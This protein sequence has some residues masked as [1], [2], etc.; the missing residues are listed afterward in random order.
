[1]T[2][3]EAPKG[4]IVNY[5]IEKVANGYVL[6]VTRGKDGDPTKFVFTYKNDLLT[7]LGERL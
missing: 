3:T 5:R 6:H 4:P 2:A 1:M 7:Y